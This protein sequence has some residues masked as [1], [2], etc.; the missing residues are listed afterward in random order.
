MESFH[1]WPTFLRSTFLPKINSIGLICINLD[2]PWVVLKGGKLA[3]KA[4]LR[5]SA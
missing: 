3:K 5:V 2:C 4:A 1:D